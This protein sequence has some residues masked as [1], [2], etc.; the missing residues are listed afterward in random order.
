M[1]KIIALSIMIASLVYAKGMHQGEVMESMNSGGYTYIKVHEKDKSYWIATTEI[2]ITKGKEIAFF[3]EMRMHKF[4]S[5]TLNR[6]FEDILFVSKVQ[7]AREAKSSHKQQ[8]VHTLNTLKS[9]LE[10]TKISPYKTKDTLSVEET[11]LKAKSLAGKI[12]QIRGKVTK[13]SPMIMKKNWIHIQDGTGDSHT[14]D[15][16]FTSDKESAKVGDI[17]TAKGVLV[18]DKDFGYGYFYPV[19]IQEASFSK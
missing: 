15:I 1:K 13:V 3:E 19:I 9:S 11:F 6:T 17:V 16:V 7:G 18:V 14:D 10:K 2:N 8:N 5:K 4:H 12:V